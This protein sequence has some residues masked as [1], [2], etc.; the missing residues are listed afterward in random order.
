MRSCLQ[1]AHSF[2]GKAIKQCPRTSWIIGLL[3]IKLFFAWFIL[4]M[5][6]ISDQNK[7][8]HFLSAHNAP[9]S[10]LLLMWSISV[11]IIHKYALPAC[12]TVQAYAEVECASQSLQP[13]PHCA[14]LKV[15][16]ALLVL[17]LPWLHLVNPAFV[18]LWMDSGAPLFQHVLSST[19]SIWHPIQSPHGREG[20]CG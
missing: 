18:S 10:I 17:M 2:A 6:N 7:L 3:L 1:S 16:N 20:E 14:P 4:V 12:H 11:V 19:A 9:C 5:V 13:V 15:L 8:S